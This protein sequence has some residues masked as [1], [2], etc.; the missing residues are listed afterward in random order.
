MLPGMGKPYLFRCP[1]TGLNVQGYL[2]EGE[3][4][5]SDAPQLEP[6][7]CLACGLFHFVDPATGRLLSNTSDHPRPA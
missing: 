7:T 3:A 5:S 2:E 4:K 6:V 1:T